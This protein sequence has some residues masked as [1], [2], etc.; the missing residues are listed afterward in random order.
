MHTIPA[1]LLSDKHYMQSQLPQLTSEDF[2][3]VNELI[4]SQLNSHVDLVEEI[5]QY[6]VSA[7]GKRVRPLLVL[8]SARACNF[9]G[10]DH[11]LLAAVIEF[12]HTATLLHDD[13]VDISDLRR[14]LPTANAKWGNAPSVLVGDFIYSRAFQMMVALSNLQVMSVLSNATNLIAEGEVW[15]LSNI[16]NIN[17]SEADYFRVI[18]AKTA[19]LFS[20]SCESA[21]IL[22]Q[23]SPE[24]TAALTA[25]GLNLGLAFQLIDDLLDYQ[26]NSEEMGKNV[27]DDL[28]EGKPTLPLIY[29]MREGSTQ[30]CELIKHALTDSQEA[31]LGQILAAVT[32]SGALKYT[33]RQAELYATKAKT[34]IA[35]IPAS[36]F[37]DALLELAENS[38]KRSS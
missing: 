18:E 25:Y 38:V 13:V 12:L 28:A 29:A 17:L 3:S 14:G 16:H 24:T 2:T 11:H 27:G 30:Q 21:A 7:G 33:A 9:Q 15:Q 10:T 20:A 34:A 26:G 19:T 37:K 32:D 22:A 23:A 35:E 31:D 8:L 36:S 4:L 5:S 6:L 1:R